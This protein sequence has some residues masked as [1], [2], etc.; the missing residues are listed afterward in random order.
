MITK[1]ESYH[2]KLEKDF[3]SI[4][5]EQDFS[6]TGKKSK[7]FGFWFLKNYTH[8]SEQDIS[9]N[10]IDGDDDH[11][12]DA[13]LYSDQS[14]DEKTLELFQFKFPEI[15]NVQ[16]EITQDAILKMFNGIDSLLD[17]STSKYPS[18]DSSKKN[19]FNNLLDLISDT[20]V[21]NIHI[22]F[23]SYNAG[24][25]DRNN[26]DIINSHINKLKGRITVSYVAYNADSIINLFD[27]MQRKNSVN[28][29][30][31]YVNM[32]SA[33][34]IEENKHINSWVGVVQANSLLTEVDPMLTVIFDENIRL[35]EKKSSVNNEIIQTARDR[36]TSSM[37][38]FYNNGITI[39]CDSAKNSPGT[40]TLALSGASIVNGCQTV[41]SLAADYNQGSLQDDVHVLVRVIEIETY[42]ERSL[43]TQYLNSQ[44]PV[45]ESYFI[46][47][48]HIIRDLQEKLL[49]KGYFLERQI[50][51][52]A[53][54]K[55]YE[56][57]VPKELEN[58]T[59]LKLEDTIQHYVGAFSNKDAPQAKRGK[60]ALFNRNNIEDRL[61][62][63]SA[64]KVIE[65]EKTYAA[66]SKVITKYRKNRRNI[67]NNDFTTFLGIS[68]DE[69]NSDEY[70]FVNTGDIVILNAVTLM[71]KR[72]IG[73]NLN[74]RIA[75]SIMMI[76]DI[77]KDDNQLRQLPPATMT[78]QNGIYE[79]VQRKIIDGENVN[80]SDK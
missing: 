46:A 39:I 21:Y 78:K 52:L 12:I 64:D 56:N 22:N 20:E 5:K 72:S 4:I 47:N 25:V 76:K 50:N 27:K 77:I 42:E 37:F 1:Y 26:K 70:S 49:S 9:E 40:S 35:F 44:N 15:Q 79:A 61:K 28:L 18:K 67:E 75:T 60:G 33:Y 65:A 23:V 7:A 41:T 54:I 34:S 14:Q 51:E 24:I 66:I 19:D 31:K 45:R 32:Q 59:V 43:I 73:N 57:N 63:I 71:K 17:T 58:I 62:D 48:N 29:S 69:Y 68:P 2:A 10:L 6:G 8:L 13:Y 30:L 11:G 38:Y 3:E 36:R 80:N 74:E 16:R 55:Q 53:Y